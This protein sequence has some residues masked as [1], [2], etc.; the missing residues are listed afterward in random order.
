MLLDKPDFIDSIIVEELDTIPMELLEELE[1]QSHFMDLLKSDKEDFWGTT[2][3]AP[4]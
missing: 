2:D 1:A 3:V 4:L